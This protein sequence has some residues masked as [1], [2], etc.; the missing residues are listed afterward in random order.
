[1]R[2][3]ARGALHHDHRPDREPAT[4]TAN[5]VVRKCEL[6]NWTT[7]SDLH[8]HGGGDDLKVVDCDFIITDNATLAP[9]DD[10]RP[11]SGRNYVTTTD[12]TGA[13]RHRLGPASADT[14]AQGRALTTT[15]G[16][17]G[18]RRLHLAERD[19]RVLHGRTLLRVRSNVQTNR[20]AAVRLL[21][22][23]T[24]PTTRPRAVARGQHGT[25]AYARALTTQPCHVVAA[26]HRVS[27][28]R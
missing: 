12:E 16:S 24:Q 6:A 25:I 14:A 18:I 28:A 13:R 10:R 7:A 11:A 3:V 17:G 1:M 19:G 15:R 9:V 26:G 27:T 21:P 20:V 5:L 4:V 8:R 2:A 22:Y 23:S